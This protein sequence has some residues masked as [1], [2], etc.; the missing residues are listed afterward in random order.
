M[1]YSISENLACFLT[2]IKQ[3]CCYENVLWAIQCP[4]KEAG[5]EQSRSERCSSIPLKRCSIQ[6]ICWAPRSTSGS[7]QDTILSFK[8]S[9]LQSFA[10]SSTVF[11][12]KFSHTAPLQFCFHFDKYMQQTTVGR[13]EPYP[14]IFLAPRQDCQGKQTLHSQS[15]WFFWQLWRFRK[16]LPSSFQVFPTPQGSASL[17]STLHKETR[18]V[19]CVVFVAFCRLHRPPAHSQHHPFGHQHAIQQML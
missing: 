7:Q 6:G 17:S 10:V 15:T 4:W 1:S 12:S 8:L 11:T 5:E 2:L 9:S 3:E 18:P 19:V 16:S 13:R 14:F